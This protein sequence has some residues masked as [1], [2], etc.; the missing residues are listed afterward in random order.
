MAQTGR[1][2]PPGLCLHRHLPL[3]TRDQAWVQGSPCME[4]CVLPQIPLPG[5]PAPAYTVQGWTGSWGLLC[6]SRPLFG[7]SRSTSQINHLHSTGPQ[8]FLE[9]E[10]QP[11]PRLPWAPRKSKLSREPS[12]ALTLS[13]AAVERLPQ[14]RAGRLH[15]PW[16]TGAATPAGDRREDPPLGGGTRSRS[17]WGLRGLVSQGQPRC[18][19]RLLGVQRA[20]PVPGGESFLPPRQ[21]RTYRMPPND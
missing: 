19:I 6:P 21:E 8:L 11:T 12:L 13:A 2:W 3:V 7:C 10:P 14:R 16:L 9:G 18:G 15:R 20:F 17:G 1:L 4:L 5:T